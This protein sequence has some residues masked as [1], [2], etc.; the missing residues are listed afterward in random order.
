[1]LERMSVGCGST[2]GGRA[3]FSAGPLLGGPA[4]AQSCRPDPPLSHLLLDTSL[5]P[6]PRSTRSRMGNGVILKKLPGSLY[7]IPNS[8]F[9]LTNLTFLAL[10]GCNIK[11]PLPSPAALPPNLAVLDLSFNKLI[12]E[13]ARLQERRCRSRSRSRSHS[14]SLRRAA[15][16][17]ALALPCACVWAPL[18]GCCRH[19][20]L[21]RRRTEPNRAAAAP[22]ALCAATGTVSKTSRASTWRTI[23][24]PR[25]CAQLL[26]CRRISAFTACLVI[27]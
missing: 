12:G 4:T 9:Q 23:F 15:W 18:G 5:M 17:S 21:R 26:G 6:L 25:A 2:T 27:R 14:R 11:G 20:W 7:T 16:T 24:C 1:M 22:Q 8:F 3:P 19:A 10:M 13:R